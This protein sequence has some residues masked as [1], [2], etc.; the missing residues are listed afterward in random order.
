MNCRELRQSLN[1]LSGLATETTRRLDFAFYTVL[2]KAGQ[3]H[4]TI[5]SLQ[6]L[7]DSSHSLH[8]KFLA[9]SAGVEKEFQQTIKGFNDFSGQKHD[10][11]ELVAR[12]E[13]AR[14]RSE[15]LSARLEASR[16]RVELWEAREKEW[17][18]K[19]SSR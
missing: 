14:Q 8:Q 19:T 5:A 9:D 7:S 16:R 2:E 1:D 10:V 3:L 13:I 11:D 15:T 17:Q 18:K 4:S 6:E 12:L